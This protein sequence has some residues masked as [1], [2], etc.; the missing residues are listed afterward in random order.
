MRQGP[1]WSQCEGGPLAHA[2]AASV[3]S[4]RR[5]PPRPYGGDLGDLIAKEAP[6]PM[7]RGPQCCLLVPPRGAPIPQMA[8]AGPEGLGCI[9]RCVGVDDVVS[10]YTPTGCPYPPNGPRRT[11]GTRV[12]PPPCGGGRCSVSSKTPW[13]API[14]RRPGKDRRNSG[15]SAAVWGRKG[16]VH[17]LFPL[18]YP[19]SQEARTGQVGYGLVRLCGAA[20]SS[21]QALTGS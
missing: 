6:S 2:A 3:V 16:T 7:R 14:P 12:Y 18:G 15:G 8:E 19:H 10:P 4:K 20:G 17:T 9:R 13:G 5:R 11:G 1:Q 21:R